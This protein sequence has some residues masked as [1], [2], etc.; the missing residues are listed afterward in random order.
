MDVIRRNMMSQN[1]A[2]SLRLRRVKQCLAAAPIIT[3]LILFMTHS[4]AAQ[5]DDGE[6]RFSLT[7][8]MWMPNIDGTLAFEDPSM[9]IGEPNVGVGPNDYLEK[10]DFAV[11]LS[12]EARKD[13][14]S[15]FTDLIYLDFS[16]EKSSVRSVDF[17]IPNP[18]SPRLPP[19]E[20]G[21]GLNSGTTSSLKGTV[22]TLACGY[23]LAQGELATFDVFGGFRYFDLEASVD[24]ALT[25]EID[26]PNG[27][28]AFA[29]SG[30]ISQS[31]SLW[32]GV[33]GFRGRIELGNGNWFLPYYLDIGTGSSDLTWQAVFGVAYAFNWGDIKL[34][35]RHLYYDTD[36]EALLEDMRFSG[37]ALGATFRF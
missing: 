27:G 24:W 33:I 11:M 16:S 4:A 7:P 29:R 23:G 1:R 8:Y 12:G 10:L 20:V 32:D 35:Y 15:V 31:E 6:W 21:I 37:P 18:L 25:A 34:A 13:R 17:P 22:W 36:G 19:V 5:S 30:T 2:S 28:Q 9:G 14:W 3:V 26:N